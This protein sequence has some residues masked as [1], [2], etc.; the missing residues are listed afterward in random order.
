MGVVLN[1]ANRQQ[2]IGQPERRLSDIEFDVRGHIS[3]RE[4]NYTSV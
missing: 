2:F 4:F 3:V 1:Q